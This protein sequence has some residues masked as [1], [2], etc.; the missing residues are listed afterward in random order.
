VSV[1]TT[2]DPGF[3][4][5]LQGNVTGNLT[6]TA[7]KATKLD[8]TSAGVVKTTGTDGTIQ[9]VSGL[10]AS[11]ITSG[12]LAVDRGG[13]NAATT[14]ANNV[15]AGPT[16][17]GAVAPSFR[18]LDELD[19]PSLSAGKIG[20]GTFATA[21]IPELSADKI[22]SDTLAAARIP[23]LDA[24]KIA[25][26][27]LAVD[28]G[29]TNA[30][31]TAANN[32][33]AGPTSGGAVAPSFRGLD[34][35]DI[36]SLSAGKIGSG[37]FATARIPELSA[38]KITS[39]TLATARIPNLSASK[40]TTG[41]LGLPSGSTISINTSTV[42][43]T[44][45]GYLDG[46]TA[47]SAVVSKALVVDADKDIDSIRNLTA[48][49]DI[50][51]EGLVGASSNNPPV[52]A[53]VSHST[54]LRS[55]VL[56][57][58][59]RDGDLAGGSSKAALFKASMQESDNTGFLYWGGYGADTTNGTGGTTT[60]S[61][62]AG[63]G[64][65]G[66]GLTIG[67]SN[68]GSVELGYLDGADVNVGGVASKALILDSGR[69]INNVRTVNLVNTAACDITSSSTCTNM[70]IQ[71]N[72]TGELY[73]D[74]A[75]DHIFRKGTTA[76]M[77]IYDT[78]GHVRIGAGTSTEPDQDLEVD[79][80][81]KADAFVISENIGMTSSSYQLSF[82]NN[83]ATNRGIGFYIGRSPNLNNGNLGGSYNNEAMRV[84]Q[85][86]DLWM[87]GGYFIDNVLPVGASCCMQVQNEFPSTET[88][89]N[90]AKTY[91]TNTAPNWGGN[92]ILVFGDDSDG[93]TPA[94]FDMAADH[95]V[96]S[97]RLYDRLNAAVSPNSVIQM[98]TED[99]TGNTYFKQLYMKLASV[100]YAGI[101]R[102]QFEIEMAN[103]AGGNTNRNMFGIYVDGG[104]HTFLGKHRSGDYSRMIAT[105]KV[106]LS[107]DFTVDLQTTNKFYIR[108]R[109]SEESASTDLSLWEEGDDHPASDTRIYY[110][111][112][113]WTWVG[114]A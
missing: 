51:A 112:C 55:G 21:R 98:A 39:D 20:S 96:G 36:P 63:G 91:S 114:V 35:L 14:A 10:A 108:T 62:G 64:I 110:M 111:R 86:S 50:T 31:T 88:K 66:N 61:V 80:H 49:G 67:S 5:T 6:G 89:F 102:F 29:G 101:Y 82:F 104:S 100:T 24:S 30:A 105:E 45:L 3:T 87:R 90:W 46:V 109:C 59:N 76:R 19:I 113:T 79:N 2:G 37:T 94:N 7:D 92:R 25:S 27:T 1:T 12:T 28:R 38:D 81:M 16:S 43:E 32:V 78:N 33:F 41:N 8:V 65:Y 47:G 18:G 83:Q 75:N 107:L 60:F 44:E 52:I 22:T 99:L 57:V 34:E 42:D 95:V 74:S 84:T 71:H 11:E 85:H 15:F 70:K 97:H 106:H 4:G 26:G 68:V 103:T 53:K 77:R 72:G 17:G 73:F 58:N 93:D 48:D 13:T 23:S 54:G 40:I 69:D 9:I 56:S